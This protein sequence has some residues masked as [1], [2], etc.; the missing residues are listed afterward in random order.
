MK[1]NNRKLL[2]TVIFI[3]IFL[4]FFSHTLALTY[5]D[6]W[7]IFAH[8]TCENN[9]EVVCAGENGTQKSEKGWYYFS[10]DIHHRDLKD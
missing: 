10:L 7:S 2:D 8:S 3:F 5:R 1:W 4:H 6:S 9:P